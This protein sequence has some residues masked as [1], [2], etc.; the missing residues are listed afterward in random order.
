MLL[1]PNSDGLTDFIPAAR[2][3]ELLRRPAAEASEVR[4]VLAK[5]MN[6]ER[7]S[8]GEMAAL[9]SVTSPDSLDDMFA[10]ARQLKRMVYGNR[11]VLFAPLY[12]GNK[13]INSCKYCG[14]RCDN[15]KVVRRTL[16]DD[17][18]RAEV[19]VLLSRGH[20]RLVINYGEHPDYDA[21]TIAHAVEVIYAVKS[22]HGGIRRINVNCAHWMSKAIAR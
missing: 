15:N 11:I 3:E 16:A 8:L 12:I 22:E 21:E 19:S 20:K 4:N 14:F 6:K 2:I 10:A 17:E 18:L 1:R 7:L 9:L 5:S 13:C